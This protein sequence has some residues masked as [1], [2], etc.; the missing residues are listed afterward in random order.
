MP[1]GIQFIFVE[2]C[3]TDLRSQGFEGRG[4]IITVFSKGTNQNGMVCKLFWCFITFTENPKPLHIH[5]RSE[6]RKLPRN[7]VV[8]RLSLQRLLFFKLLMSYLVSCKITKERF[9]FVL[10]KYQAREQHSKKNWR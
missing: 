6:G 7:A 9:P 3:S 1:R 8:A 2:V 5:M 10:G 4:F